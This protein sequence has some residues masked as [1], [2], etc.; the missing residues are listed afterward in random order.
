MAGAFRHTPQRPGCIGS[1]AGASPSQVYTVQV[2]GVIYLRSMVNFSDYSVSGDKYLL[3][4]LLEY[5]SA[6]DSD[7]LGL[8]G[9][10]LIARYRLHWR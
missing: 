7:L 5:C 1:G 2:A 10:P 6:M 9:P 8:L 3:K 4:Y